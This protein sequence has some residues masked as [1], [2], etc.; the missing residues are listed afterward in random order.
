MFD[1]TIKQNTDKATVLAIEKRWKVEQRNW[2]EQCW[3]SMFVLT[4]LLS[5]FACQLSW[6]GLRISVSNILLAAGLVVHP[7]FFR[8]G[9]T[10]LQITY[11][12]L[13][14]RDFI[15]IKYFFYNLSE[16]DFIRMNLLYT[17]A[18]KETLWIPNN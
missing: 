9:A 12:I 13:V 18:Q 4:L 14:I 5:A 1:I 15:G 11:Y 3:F 6:S 17:H 2:K 7:N 16:F 10:D 8:S